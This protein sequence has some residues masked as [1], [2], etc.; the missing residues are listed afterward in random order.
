M[1]KLHVSLTFSLLL[2]CLFS[3]AQTKTQSAKTESIKVWGNCDMCKSHIEKAAKAGGA[4]YAVWNP[5]TKLLTVKYASFKTNGIKI[6]QKVA[7]AG[8]DTK[9]Y[10][11]D[12]K[13]YEDLDEC[14]QYERKAIETAEKPKQ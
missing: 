12:A 4:S 13:A 14:C 1:K 2:L 6:Q 10:T 9:D 3:F 5:D 7:A 8:Y 11:G